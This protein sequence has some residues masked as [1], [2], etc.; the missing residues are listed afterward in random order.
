M[1]LRG[2]WVGRSLHCFHSFT[3]IHDGV[4]MCV[5]GGDEAK[6]RHRTFEA[7]EDHDTCWEGGKP[8]VN[9][10]NHTPAHT[11]NAH[12]SIHTE[13]SKSV[14]M[15]AYVR[16]HAL[17]DTSQRCVYDCDPAGPC[18][19]GVTTTWLWSW[20]SELRSFSVRSSCTENTTRTYSHLSP[21]S[22]PPL[23]PHKQ[24]K[25][26]LQTKHKK[27]IDKYYLSRQNAFAD[28]LND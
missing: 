22:P 5:L 3:I 11:E 10:H 21:P 18:D 19:P 15:R 16:V 25:S 7:K 8:E 9:T 17:T 13:M 20:V 2:V 28:I 26:P 12:A 24:V 27:S 14:C 23:P 4:C 1:L 6:C